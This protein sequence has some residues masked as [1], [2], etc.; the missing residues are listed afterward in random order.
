MNA[1]TYLKNLVRGMSSV[2]DICPAIG[3]RQIIACFINYDTPF[4]HDIYFFQV[5]N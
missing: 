5:L 2:M 4:S 3:A 1:K